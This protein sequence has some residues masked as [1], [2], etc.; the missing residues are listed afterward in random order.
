MDEHELD[1]LTNEPLDGEILAARLARDV[2][3]PEDALAWA[4]QLGT[5]LGQAHATGR[6]HGQVSPAAVVITY[7]G[8][9]ILHPSPTRAAQALRYRAPEQAL[10]A[11]ADWRSDIFAYGALLYEMA[12]GRPAFSG[13][14]AEL[15]RAIV[16]SFPSALG[17]KTAIH[18]AMEGVVAGCL[19]KDPARR[20]QR[21]QNAVIELKLA[22]RSLPKLAEFKIR[23]ARPAAPVSQ[24]PHVLGI[25][26]GVRTPTTPPGPQA[27]AEGPPPASQFRRR[28]GLIGFGLLALAATAVAAALY[29]HQRSPGQ[30]LRF[31][32]SP[33]EHASY[34][35]TPSISP[36]GRNLA[37]SAIGPEGRRM[38]WLRP[39]DALHAATILGTE[40]GFAPFWSP[41]SQ[42]IGFFAGRKMKRVSLPD[43]TITEICDAESLTG[44]GAWN[45][46]GT[47]L[48][49]PSLSGGLYRVAAEGGRLDPVVRLDER[50]GEF[51]ALWP[52]F[53]P[54]GQHFIYFLLTDYPDTTG[55]YAGALDRPG[56]RRLF[57]SETNAVYSAPGGGNGDQGYLLYMRDRDLMAQAFSTTHLT[58]EGDSFAVA[59]NIGSV[60]SLALAPIS[61]SANG[62]LAYQSVGKPTR[63][64]VWMDRNGLTAGA[65]S[66]PGEWGPPR[67]SP[68]G[69]R[70]AVARLRADGASAALWIVDASGNAA[71]FSAGSRN[72][73][74][75]VW[76]PDG[77]R[78][79]FSADQDGQRD[80]FVKAV[81]GNGA[82]RPELLFKSAVPKYPT[83]WSRD[84]RYLLF[85]V[86]AAAT[87]A[88]V[89][90]LS[91]A[92][93]R[94][95]P[96]K[97]TIFSEDYGT[98]SPDGRWLAYQSDDSGRNEVYVERFAPEP[99]ARRRWQV[100]QGGGGLPRW[101]ADCGEIYYLTA[102][103]RMMAVRVNGE[104]GDFRFDAP[105][106]LFQTRPIPQTWNL[107][108]VA[109][110]GQR[111][112]MNLP[113]E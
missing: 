65:P 28:F 70:A 38:L 10:G 63:Q 11:V 68:D 93:R 76:S 107:Y 86:L 9:R 91:L 44:G 39:L 62:I 34:P 59:D 109:P 61:V 105:S 71:P 98:V 36:D 22:G 85:G 102:G 111:F 57:T 100:S 33:P 21:I 13:E 60:R 1:F 75:P 96:V 108:D 49:A 40:E 80:L 8:A 41:D 95:A 66:E 45:R 90:S 3:S 104:D 2:L 112:V 30:V 72:E 64:L 23:Q 97:Q 81:S 42:A 6:V 110:D 15:D 46:E 92:D 4:I 88:D 35:G 77:S 43:F 47:I 32:V 24:A 89:W 5:L 99:D 37:F 78:I 27:L 17:G 58:L 83:D 54:D 25:L 50:K 18:A 31:A 73:R 7:A 87:R 106:T 26:S 52:Q 14:G 74:S 103:G 113:L 101:R 69:R 84:G 48:F 51:A 67:I 20:R 79:A 56:S 94:A 82:S 55:V 53:L 12:A 16:E 29:I 19:E